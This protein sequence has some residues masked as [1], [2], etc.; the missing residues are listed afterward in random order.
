[1][2]K[3]GG[4]SLSGSV[5]FAMTPLDRL[6]MALELTEVE[7]RIEQI[8]VRL[9]PPVDEDVPERMLI[10]GD[11]RGRAISRIGALE[12]RSKEILEILWPTDEE[13]AS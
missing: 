6:A 9:D 4:V 1:M 2:N 3:L 7:R 8:R 11:D 12:R 5:G 10:T 13:E